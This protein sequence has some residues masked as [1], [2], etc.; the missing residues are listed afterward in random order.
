MEGS[1]HSIYVGD[2]LFQLVPIIA[3]TKGCHMIQKAKANVD[4]LGKIENADE[5]GL[6]KGKTCF[7][8]MPIADMDGYEAG[9][10]LRVYDHLI[11]PACQKAGYEVHRADIVAASNY[12]IIDILRKILESD[13]VICDLSGRNPNVLYELGVRQ[14]FNLPTVLI[15][16][17][18]TPKIFDIQ[19]L[20]YTE[21][22]HNLRI[23]EVQKERDRIQKSISET[24]DNPHDVNSM[25][26]L[27]GVKPAPLPHKIE[28]SNETSVILES[29]KDISSRISGLES[30]RPTSVPN[31]KARRITP[32]RL[33]NFHFN[34]E[35]F[36]E[37][38][39][40]FIKGEEI[41]QLV[42][43]T[44]NEV[45]VRSGPN[46]LT[47]YLFSNPETSLITGIPF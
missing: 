30:A 18:K 5:P 12:I 36:T 45:V 1:G 43:V 4:T 25:I 8:I 38:E 19:G 42:S 11:S 47:K 35:A 24:A 2:F 10:F 32:T 3:K 6:A 26:Q 31:N 23:D 13:M 7:V 27:L 44:D 41:G 33:A 28:L 20:R 14:A 37:G 9:H 15:K 21:Y 16:D 34:E 46:S 40:L 39:T 17:I 29:L 22:N